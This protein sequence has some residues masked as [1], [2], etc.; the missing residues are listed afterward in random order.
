MT[1]DLV[2]RNGR[3]VDGTGAAPTPGDIAIVG[4]T[5][6][7]MGKVEGTGRREIDAGG[8]AITPGFIDLHTHLDA[9]VGWDPL[10]AP[11]T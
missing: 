1:Y 2:I 8:C 9:Q 7:A 10:L 3:L 4:D 11:L 6:A 5:I